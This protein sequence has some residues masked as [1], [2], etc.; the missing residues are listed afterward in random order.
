MKAKDRKRAIIN[1]LITKK[2][3]ITGGE[4]AKTFDVSRQIIIRDIAVSCT[5]QSAIERE[6]QR[7]E[8]IKAGGEFTPEEKILPTREDFAAVYT[9]MLNSF[10]AGTTILKHRDICSRLTSSKSGTS[11]GYIKLK[12][13]IMILKELNIVGIEEPEQEVYKISIHY[14]S[15]KTDL[16]KSNLLRRLRLQQRPKT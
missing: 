8:E 15:S 1:L 13:I 2:K 12:F 3:A 9:Y 7:F 6:M 16:E 5:R 11:V 4:L 10:R 14:S